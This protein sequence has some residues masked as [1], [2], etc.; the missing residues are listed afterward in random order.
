MTTHDV[1]LFLGAILLFVILVSL[2]RNRKKPFPNTIQPDSSNG[3]GPWD[4]SDGGGGG[5]D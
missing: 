2:W 1:S 4:V 5:G 3:G